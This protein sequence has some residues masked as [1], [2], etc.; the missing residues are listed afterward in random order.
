[1]RGH[2]I[3]EAIPGARGKRINMLA[4]WFQKKL[5]APLVFKGSCNHVI[6]NTWLEKSLLPALPP[7]T[8][9]VMDNAAFHKTPSTQRLIEAAG[10]HLLYLPPYSPDFNPIEHCWHTI[11]SWLRPRMASTSNLHALLCQAICSLYASP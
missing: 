7:N 11:K 1:L 10:C 9:I 3:V 4:G 2:K 6:F 8:T 5:I